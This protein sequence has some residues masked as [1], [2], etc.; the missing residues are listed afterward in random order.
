MFKCD[1]LTHNCGFLRSMDYNRSGIRFSND[2][3]PRSLSLAKAN[4]GSIKDMG[5]MFFLLSKC[6]AD[7]VV[8]RPQSWEECLVE[9]G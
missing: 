9:R 1:F 5:D 6:N 2:R 4:A 3:R 7:L 8:E